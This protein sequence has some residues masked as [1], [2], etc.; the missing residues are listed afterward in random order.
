MNQTTKT[1]FPIRNDD[2]LRRAVALANSLWDSKPGSA[3]SELLEVVGTLIEDY[4]SRQ[5][6]LPPGDPLETIRYKL[7]E[8]GWSQNDLARASGLTSGRVSELLNR[9]RPLTLDQVRRIS[10][11][12]GLPAGLLVHDTLSDDDTEWVALS[13]P[14]MTHARKLAQSRNVSVSALLEMLVL[15]ADGAD[16]VPRRGVAS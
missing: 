11:A 5:P 10:T 4:E 7:S 8:L 3:D 9:K 14:A 1:A 13:A 15:S 2:D 12:L 6:G 16:V